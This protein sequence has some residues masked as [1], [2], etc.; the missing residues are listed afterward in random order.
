MSP[1]NLMRLSIGAIILCSISFSLIGLNFPAFTINENQT[2]YL[3]S[4]SA[5]VLAGIYGLTLTGFIFF[6]N[7][8]SREELDDTS[9]ADAI[10]VLKLRYFK[11]L[12]FISL[13]T[14]I[15]ISFCNLVIVTVSSGNR[16]ASTILMNTAQSSYIINLIVITYFIFDV[17]TPKKIERASQKLQSEIDTNLNTEKDGD[18]RQFLENYNRIQSI[19]FD[20][21][22]IFKEN[23]SLSDSF[24]SRK[25]QSVNMTKALFNMNNID[26]K[27]FNDVRSLTKLRNAIVHGASPKVSQSMVDRSQ[28]ILNEISTRFNQQK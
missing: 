20:N 26:S 2:L 7:E 15:T 22:K 28:E 12:T 21:S 25:I 24:D 14:V 4:T 13:H 16:I 3:F 19:I 10:D 6:R 1:N 23:T 5:Q 9:L 18:L 17:L 8:L 11:L 27:L